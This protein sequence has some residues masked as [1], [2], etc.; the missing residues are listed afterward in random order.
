MLLRKK[1]TVFLAAAMMMMVMSAAPA[2]A[3][4][5]TNVSKQAGAGSI[6]TYN[7]V[8]DT[9]TP[10]KDHGGFV[11]LTDGS[12]SYDVFIHRTLP[13]GARASGPGDSLCDGV[14]VDDVEACLAP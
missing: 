11:T 8:T 4:Q 1:L 5:C 7:I 14:G 3:H 10:T 2:F 13:E 12:T 6:G 9:F